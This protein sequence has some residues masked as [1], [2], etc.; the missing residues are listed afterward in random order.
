MMFD[1]AYGEGDSLM[2]IEE[3]VAEEFCN[4]DGSP[5]NY[6]CF[7]THTSELCEWDAGTA[8]YA[9]EANGRLHNYGTLLV[10]TFWDLGRTCLEPDDV[11][12]VMP[13]AQVQDWI[14]DAMSGNGYQSDWTHTELEVRTDWELPDWVNS[15]RFQAR[16]CNAAYS[17]RNLTRPEAVP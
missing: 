9:V 16:S 10:D 3:I 12:K 17:F 14:D 11:I 5:T 2:G 13:H 4:V 1:P 8:I 7:K 15:V 6:K